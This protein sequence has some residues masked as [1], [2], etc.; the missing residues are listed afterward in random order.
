MLEL[1]VSSDSDML[2]RPLSE[3]D[4]PVGAI[5]GAIVREGNYQI[6]DGSCTLQSGDRVVVFALPEALGKV[7]RFFA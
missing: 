6:P 4:F 1:Q 5:I 2:D 3:L 7:E